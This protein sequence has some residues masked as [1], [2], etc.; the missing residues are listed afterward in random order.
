MFYFSIIIPV[1][2][3]EEYLEDAVKSVINQTIGFSNIQLIIVDDGSPDNSYKIYTYYQNLYP[4]NIVCVKQKNSGVSAARNRGLELAKGQ[5]INFMDADDMWQEDAMEKAMQ[6][7][8][9]HP[10]TDVAACR[11]EYFD[12]KIG[13]SHPLDWKFKRSRIIDVLKTPEAVQMHIASCFIRKQALGNRKFTNRMKYAE[14]SRLITS[15]ILDKNLYGVIRSVHY[16][17]RKRKDESSAV[18][19]CRFDRDYY[20]P[21][22]QMFHE[23]ILKE[24]M[25]R[26]GY[27]HP[28]VQYAIAYDLQW[29]IKHPVPDG[30]LSDYEAA[31]YQTAICSVLG[32]IDDRAILAQRNIWSEHKLLA[33]SM[34]YETD[35]ARNMIQSGS[36]FYFH[37]VPV[38]SVKSSAFL[39]IAYLKI[40]NDVLYIE[41][42][43]NT[44]L[45]KK[46]Y[47]ITI[48][49]SNGVS[50]SVADMEDFRRR[51][52]MSV[53]G[54]YYY[55]QWFKAYVSVSSPKDLVL[56]FFVSYK[57]SLSAEINIGFTD[58]CRLNTS[59]KDGYMVL[60][61]KILKRTGKS[62]LIRDSYNCS[63]MGEEFKYCL[64]LF[65]KKAWKIPFYRAASIIAGKIKKKDIWIVSDRE[66]A[67]GDNGEA[68]FRYLNETDSS[69]RVYFALSKKSG[70]WK[71]VKRLGRVINTDSVWYKFIFL[72][73]S[74][75]ISSHAN[76]S[77][78]NPFGKG[79]RFV[80]DLYKFDFIFLQHGII[81]D[82]LSGWLNRA[83]KDIRIFVTSGVPE[84][85]SIICG[86]YGYGAETVKLTG[87]PRYDR[88][89]RN[90]E[91][92]KRIAI[93]PT[94]RKGLEEYMD[95][96]GEEGEDS[97][98]CRTMFYRFYNDLIHD[99]RL[100][101]KMKE[102]GYTG[103][104]CLHP[105]FDSQKYHFKDGE[106]ICVWDGSGGY[107]S[108]FENTDLLITD[109]SSV[110]FDYAY[111][112]KPVIYAQFDKEE[113]FHSH[114][115]Q[116]GYF[117]YERDG[118]G[119]VLNTLDDVIK[120][121]ISY[122]EHACS[123][124]SIY[125]NRID[126]FFPTRSDKSWNNSEAVYQEIIKIC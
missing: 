70:D 9:E 90:G 45:N 111:L 99:E 85:Q 101:G 13:F 107:K 20:L 123:I 1:Y 120:E 29:R 60:G 95:R 68:F 100:N 52:K 31:Q 28:Y 102:L 14:D 12:A 91:K 26:F 43:I 114:S 115:Y 126:Q 2:K 73:S 110:F 57:N 50:T 41:G 40:E 116:E 24:S 7:F 94:W 37:G 106:R 10:E 49:G 11:M 80:K 51:E 103:V 59:T 42:L 30:V 83:N 112:K 46:D 81:K 69:H 108:L 23:D 53:Y 64:S 84:Y 48:E 66:D 97:L 32:R 67:A 121:I 78:I 38:L 93:I 75:I 117:D 71:R 4:D 79:K 54:H 34:K 56:T 36:D 18:D 63:I 5:Y 22:V 125:G 122:M 17:Y 118:F 61:N 47:C 16:L 35:A 72:L 113:F 55:E 98:F 19:R 105:L 74:K 27:I 65:R 96:N 21:S 44:P 88:L 77:T 124:K 82:D 62:L 119:P 15:V 87:L 6:F 39:K 92:H 89:C 33:L 104:F 3:A 8:E 58:T 86:D 25:D 76:D 109:Y